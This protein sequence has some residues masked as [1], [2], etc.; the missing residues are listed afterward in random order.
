MARKK[1]STRFDLHEALGQRSFDHRVV[2]TYIF[3][4]RLFEE[5]CLE[6]LT[7]FSHNDNL[8]VM[9]DR[10]VYEKLLTGPESYRPKR[11]NLRYL[12]HPVAAARGVFHPKILLFA[13][14]SKGRLI[15]GSANT[16]RPGITS[17]AELVG[18]YDYEEGKAEVFLPLFRSA[19]SFLAEAARRWPAEQLTRNLEEMLRAAP[20]LAAAEGHEAVGDFTL[21]HN[22]NAPLWDQ[23]RAG[24]ARRPHGLKV[25]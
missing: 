15:V 22:L 6:R 7:S 23:V 24:V 12:L 18:C 9:L 1:S 8:T 25:L 14:P 16:T 11:A 17:N 10:G 19:F 20:W 4:P 5:Y 21:L 2:C 13:S 3:D